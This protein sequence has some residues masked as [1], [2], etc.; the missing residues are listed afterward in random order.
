V[1]L[2]VEQQVRE[3]EI[4]IERAKESCRLRRN[5]NNSPDNFVRAILATTDTE[6]HCYTSKY[7]GHKGR[8]ALL[9]SVAAGFI[10]VAQVL[11]EY[12]ANTNVVDEKANTMFH[13]L[14]EASDPKNGLVDLRLLDQAYE[15]TRQY[16]DELLLWRFNAEG[17]CA[18]KRLTE[19]LSMD[20]RPRANSNRGN[21]I[22]TCTSADHYPKLKAYPPTH[23]RA[24]IST[25]ELQMQKESQ[26]ENRR[27]ALQ[28]TYALQAQDKQ[29]LIGEHD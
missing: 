10:K 29:K 2:Q 11:L 17:Q 22:A 6:L 16:C 25:L 5:S 18:Q 7:R 3:I 26:L 20:P 4:I 13:L 23:F 9:V 27:V 12:G 15:M 8:C 1:D 24:P 21:T 28:S 19:L 14:A